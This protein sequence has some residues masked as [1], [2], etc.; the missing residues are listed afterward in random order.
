MTRYEISILN[1]RLPRVS[2]DVLK[3]S[4]VNTSELARPVNA[5][6][7]LGLAIPLLLRRAESIMAQGG[8]H[9]LRLPWRQYARCPHCYHPLDQ[10]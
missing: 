10:R 9:V 3:L 1:P 2:P 6:V 4:A 7:G 5:A 8:V